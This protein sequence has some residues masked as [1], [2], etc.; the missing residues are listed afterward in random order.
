MDSSYFR[1][2]DCGKLEATETLYRK[3]K[4]YSLHWLAAVIVIPF[5][6]ILPYFMSYTTMCTFINSKR[7]SNREMICQEAVSVKQWER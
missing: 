7:C 3:R 5:P 2:N 4:S 1:V 6:I